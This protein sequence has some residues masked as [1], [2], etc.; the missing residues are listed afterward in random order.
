MDMK[1]YTKI[2]ILAGF[3]LLTAAIKVAEDKGEEE[4]VKKLKWAL[5]PFQFYKNIIQEEIKPINNR[6]YWISD[7]SKGGY[8]IAQPNGNML[9]RA[10]IITAKELERKLNEI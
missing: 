4:L 1:P 7:F 10:K 8:V 9:K 6:R 2:E 3:V 5:M